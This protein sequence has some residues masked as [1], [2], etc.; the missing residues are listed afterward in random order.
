MALVTGECAAS[1]TFGLAGFAIE[2]GAV[3]D[4]VS[5]DFVVTTADLLCAAFFAAACGGIA[6]FVAEAICFCLA[7]I[8]T[9][10]LVANL[11][12]EAIIDRRARCGTWA[13]S[14]EPCPS[15]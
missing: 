2:V 15:K 14:D 3:T 4:F 13:T 12:A 9:L 6:D 5:F 1:E 7:S 11:V 8:D 10:F